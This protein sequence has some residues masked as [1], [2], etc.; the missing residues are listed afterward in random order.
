M[1]PINSTHILRSCDGLVPGGGGLVD[2]E[3]ALQPRH[4]EVHRHR[5]VLLPVVDLADLANVEA[6]RKVQ[7]LRVRQHCEMEYWND[8]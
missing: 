3:P 7:A 5:E 8:F 4:A 2:P 1:F 6:E